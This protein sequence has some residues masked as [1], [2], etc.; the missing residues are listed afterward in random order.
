M[1]PRSSAT[2]AVPPCPGT[3]WRDRGLLQRTRVRSGVRCDLPFPAERAAVGLSDAP[4]ELRPSGFL[5]TL[6]GDQTFGLPRNTLWPNFHGRAHLARL[7]RSVWGSK[8]RI[9]LLGIGPCSPSARGARLI[10]QP[11]RRD[12]IMRDLVADASIAMAQIGPCPRIVAVFFK[13][14]F[15]HSPPPLGNGRFQRTGRSVVWRS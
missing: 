7:I 8:H 12:R 14:G 2:A 6:L 4:H 13:C 11:A 3:L 15:W 9:D 10:N 1:C 5:E